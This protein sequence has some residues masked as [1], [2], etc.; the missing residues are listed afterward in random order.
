[1]GGLGHHALA[2]Q[3]LQFLGA[4]HGPV[5]QV[6]PELVEGHAVRCSCRRKPGGAGFQAAQAIV[7]LRVERYDIER[8]VE[9]GDE[10]QEQATVQAILVKAIGRQVGGCH[11][12]HTALPPWPRT[13][14]R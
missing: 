12:H 1:M 6:M 9:L 4:A 14:G 5:R 2:A 13:G 7:L 3:N 8:R 10:G 11:Q